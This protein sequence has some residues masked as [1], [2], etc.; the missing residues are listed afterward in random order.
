VIDLM[1]SATKETLCKIIPPEY[2]NYLDVFDPEGPMQKLPPL[3]L[4]FDF[5]IKL[6]PTKPLPRLA[7]PYHMNP[8]E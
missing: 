8:A 2:H 4:G 6:D 5:E 1:P 7:Q 3:Q